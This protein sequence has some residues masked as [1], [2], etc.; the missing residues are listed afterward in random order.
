MT[1]ETV[2]WQPIETAP[3]GERVLLWFADDRISYAVPGY[4]SDERFAKRP[5]PYWSSLCLE[6]ITGVSWI[7]EH[8]PTHWA[9]LLSGP[10]ETE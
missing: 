5:R 4:W 9:P 7:R 10:Q 1:T 6:G 2:T 3:K 8:Q